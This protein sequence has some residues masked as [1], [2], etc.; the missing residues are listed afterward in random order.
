MLRHH[1]ARA[2][3]SGIAR[4]VQAA[5]PALLSGL[6]LVACEAGEG[7]A[8]L[9]SEYVDP[10]KAVG[11]DVDAGAG[12]GASGSTL[13]GGASD[14][15]TYDAR[16]GGNAIHLGA[17]TGALYSF[18][19]PWDGG[20]TIVPGHFDEDELTDLLLYDPSTGAFVQERNSG[21]ESFDAFVGHWDAGWD[22]TVLQLDGDPRNDVFL[23]NATAGTWSRCLGRGAG[24]FDC[25][26]GSWDKGWKVL[27]ARL[28]DDAIDDVL[29]YNP[30]LGSWC[31]VASAGTSPCGT[32]D[33]GWDVYPA[34]LDGDG[35]TDFVMYGPQKTGPNWAVA[36]A[37]GA[38][39]VE[40]SGTWPSGLAIRVGDFDADRKADV[41]TY[42]PSDGEV[43]VQLSRGSGGLH[44]F[45]AQPPV[46]VALSGADVHVVDQ[47]RDGRS[48]ILLSRPATGQYAL[49][50]LRPDGGLDTR[51]DHWTA[52]QAIVA[53]QTDTREPTLQRP[54]V[55]GPARVRTTMHG[56]GAPVASGTDV[57]LSWESVG[58][59]QLTLEPGH[60][61]VTGRTQH[62]VKP[63]SDTY[64]SLTGAFGGA[65][66]ATLPVVTTPR[67]PIR[68]TLW[69]GPWYRPEAPLTVTKL[70]AD[71]DADTVMYNLDWL[72]F[73][74]FNTTDHPYD[75][76]KYVSFCRER[77]AEA[78]ATQTYLFFQTLLPFDRTF[79]RAHRTEVLDAL[80]PCFTSP[81]VLG[82]HTVDEPTLLDPDA[83]GWTRDSLREGY[84][85]FKERFPGKLVWYNEAPWRSAHALRSW[86][87][88]DIVSIDSY[89]L[90]QASTTAL[91]A[92]LDPLVRV[93]NEA[94][95]GRERWFIHQ[96]FPANG[97]WP[98][99]AELHAMVDVSVSNGQTGISWWGLVLDDLGPEH[100]IFGQPTYVPNAA[101]LASM[102][103]TNAYI[104]TRQRHP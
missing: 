34:D 74:Y 67:M 75:L 102:K 8:S 85:V 104:R 9:E 3:R 29:L 36:L 5:R 44:Q 32:W 90:P 52:G 41:V 46:H 59:A 51:T 58:D 12:A 84:N 19:L 81:R 97:V 83:R 53:G 55:L 49:A 62:V 38:G 16:H 71:F 28:D 10:T 77:I 82:I 42:R 48:D 21:R 100:A 99:T 18:E 95:R 80:E 103:D 64:Y 91:Q 45:Q 43:T 2:T 54:L 68:S 11:A 22:V 25:T 1:V 14:L 78:E 86:D 37:D 89:P 33:P 31:W 23:S 87:W 61:D 76:T 35:R 88:G 24:R 63:R 92:A 50:L 26:S 96:A 56:P 79:T 20:W 40:R 7:A 39:F 69:V 93:V 13:F 101:F 30:A 60:I 65:V 57:T 73:N 94:A 47:N 15:L 17:S 4:F 6:M 72:F 66:V 70:H 98:T 27:P